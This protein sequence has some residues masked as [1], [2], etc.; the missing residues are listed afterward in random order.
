L[1]EAFCELE[2]E[3]GDAIDD[4][5]WV[6]DD[7][8]LDGGG[9]A[10]D[11]AGTGVVESFAGVGDQADCERVLGEVRLKFRDQTLDLSS[12]ERGGYGKKELVVAA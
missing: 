4:Y 10:G 12:I 2:G 1:D 8:G 3:G 7:G 5:E 9:A 11:D 6:A